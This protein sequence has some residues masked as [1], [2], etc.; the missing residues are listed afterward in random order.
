MSWGSPAVST[1]SSLIMKR[2][3]LRNESRGNVGTNI[4]PG[5]GWGTSKAT[6][7]RHGNASERLCTFTIANGGN[8]AFE[9]S[10]MI[11][12]ILSKDRWS[13][14]P[15]KLPA[16]SP[17]ELTKPW[18]PSETEDGTKT[19]PFLC[20]LCSICGKSL[21]TKSLAALNLLNGDSFNLWQMARTATYFSP[22]ISKSRE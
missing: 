21:P 4:K 9:V 3:P 12:R 22:C 11:R 7:G 5:M 17:F 8:G 6:T 10:C 19:H 15:K 20:D 13:G 18:N 14:M 16:S 2:K 1:S